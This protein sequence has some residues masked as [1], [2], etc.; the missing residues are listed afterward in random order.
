M[1]I[2]NRILVAVAILIATATVA[3]LFFEALKEKENL[4]RKIAVYETLLHSFFEKR[5]KEYTTFF[6]QRAAFFEKIPEIV[7]SIENKERE[8]LIDTMQEIYKKSSF[9]SS[10]ATDIFYSSDL[11]FSVNTKEPDKYVDLQKHL[12][13][14][15]SLKEKK[16]YSGFEKSEKGIFFET[17][18]PI[19]FENRFIGVV[20]TTIP[21][22]S[23]A[24]DFES[25]FKS[26]KLA[27]VSP[28]GSSR[29]NNKQEIPNFTSFMLKLFGLDFIEFNNERYFY[30]HYIPLTDISGNTLAYVKVYQ[31]VS[32]GV[33]DFYSAIVRTFAI[34]ISVIF[35]IILFLKFYL[36]KIFEKL[37]KYHERLEKAQKIAHLASWEYDLETKEF[38]VSSSLFEILEIEKRRMLSIKECNRFIVPDNREYVKKSIIKAFREKS[39][40]DIEYKI[41]TEKGNLKFIHSKGFIKTDKNGK[42]LKLFATI[43]DVTE[44]REKERELKLYKKVIDNS[45]EGVIITDSHNNIIYVNSVFTELTGYTEEEVIGKKPNILSSGRHGKDFYKKMWKSLYEKG[46]WQGEIWNRRKNGEVYPEWLNISTVKDENGKILYFAATFA[47][48][49]H[50]KL[51]KERYLQLAHYDI[52]TGLPNRLLLL[53]RLQASISHAKRNSKPFAVMFIDMDRFK[54]INDT[55]GHS[56]GDILI[57]QMGERLKS[58]FR[59][60]DTVSRVGGDEFIVLIENLNNKNNVLNLAKKVIKAV[61]KPF[62]IKGYELFVTVSIGIAIYPKDG[63]TTDELLNHADMAMYKAKEL[64]KNRFMFFE[65]EMNRFA[66]QRL[67]IEH[68]LRRAVLNGDLFLEYQPKIELETGKIVGAEALVRWEHPTKGLIPPSDFIPIAEESGMIADIG[69]LVLQ[70]GIEQ[71]NRWK[72]ECKQDMILAINVSGVQLLNPKEFIESLGFYIE[73]YPS[74]KNKIELELTESILMKNIDEMIEMMYR[75]KNLGYHLAIDDFGTGYSSLN[76]LKRFPIDTLKIDQSFI[77]TL[78]IDEKNRAIVKT[79]ISIAKTLGFK[80]IAEGVEKKDHAQFL[81]KEKCDIAQGY[82]FSRPLSPEKFIELLKAQPFVKKFSKVL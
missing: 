53:D 18:S 59:E 70:H 71:M 14:K 79:V 11:M 26:N 4:K 54:H 49:T 38:T 73:K 24:K 17:V 22:S 34:S 52:L 40:W 51:S 10:N 8:K 77:K 39:E 27:V 55:L 33:K 43:Q 19:I 28:N 29:E 9:K 16:I 56:V 13:V 32:T 58:C 36:E 65:R 66:A 64:G 41:T 62:R 60:T 68:D 75:C 78:E 80:V 76:Y 25:I 44:I 45:I 1:H 35:L 23:F 6:S 47:D 61:N 20:E 15:K 5:Q 48:I 82:F 30:R 2:K 21:A 31:D 67:S 74:L 12:L 37:N 63:T 46:F 72:S 7:L 57:K 42:P 69:S 3:N 50:H 81:K